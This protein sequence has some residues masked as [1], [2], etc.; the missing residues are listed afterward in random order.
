M[1]RLG[2]GLGHG[3]FVRRRCRSLG[4]GQAGLPQAV[5][6]FIAQ[7][8]KHREHGGL[9]RLDVQRAAAHLRHV[10]SQL[11]VHAAALN[12][13]QHPQVQARP[14]GVRRAAVHAP[15][16]AGHPPQP[17]QRAAAAAVASPAVGAAV[18]ATVP[19]PRT[20]P[21]GRVLLVARR[22][23]R[24][25]RPAL[26]AGAAAAVGSCH[27]GAR[28]A[29]DG[30]QATA[31]RRMADAPAAAAAVAAGCRHERRVS[32]AASAA[33]GGAHRHARQALYVHLP[34]EQNVDD[35][36][37]G[38]GGRVMRGARLATRGRGRRP[39]GWAG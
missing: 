1:R 15:P 24:R 33:V 14:V 11:P 12:A 31:P 7:R 30:R 26:A 34:A 19:R 27:W 5:G 13:Q 6:V 32:V 38:G 36:L 2:R 39:E 22:P 23:R 9:P 3:C 10:H 18:A 16:V 17:L 25:R 29:A 8:I 20:Q 35:A 28:L 21:R 4:S 37:A